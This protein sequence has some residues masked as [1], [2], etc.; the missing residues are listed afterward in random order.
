[1]CDKNHQRC[2]WWWWRGRPCDT[3]AHRTRPIPLHRF[4]QHPPGYHGDDHYDD[5]HHH[6][7]NLDGNFDAAADDDKAYENILGFCL[8]YCILEF[9]F[10][11]VLTQRSHHVGKL[12]YNGV[13]WLRW[14]FFW[15]G[16]M[17]KMIFFTINTISIF[18]VKPWCWCFHPH[19]YRN[20]WKPPVMFGD[21]MPFDT[22][23][24][25]GCSISQCF[26]LRFC[27][28]HKSLFFF[29]ALVDVP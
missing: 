4:R 23:T 13:W 21:K 5:D 22:F 1:M 6:D 9:S 10:G 17:I 12:L 24:Q 14:F 7:E 20:D 26:M 27:L 16:M 11:W 3:W 25:A 2:S 19:C 28:I 29:D 8:I 15:W 18:T